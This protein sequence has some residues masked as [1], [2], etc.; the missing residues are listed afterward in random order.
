VTELGAALNTET[1]TGTSVFEVRR[2]VAEWRAAHP[3]FPVIREDGP[4]GTDA[5]TNT[6]RQSVV[7]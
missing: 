4:I 3:Q 1:I 7:K 2:K 5:I 6:A